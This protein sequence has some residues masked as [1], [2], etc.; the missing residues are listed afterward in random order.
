MR[1]VRGIADPPTDLDFEALRAAVAVDAVT[2]AV[3]FGSYASGDQG[4]LSD[5]DVAVR[6]R[7]DV[8]RESRRQ[9]LDELTVEIIDAAGIEAID[10]LDLD[11]VGPRLGYEILSKGEL[12]VGDAYEAVELETRFLLRKLDFQPVKRAW[13]DALDERIRD[14]TYGRS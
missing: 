3:V 12:V 13:D 9:L 2:L 11:T 4:P 5:L 10:L 7:D 6:F 8:P 14:G 1:Y